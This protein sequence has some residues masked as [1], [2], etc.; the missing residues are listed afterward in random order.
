METVKNCRKCD[1]GSLRYQ[2]DVWGGYQNCINCG[3]ENMVWNVSEAKEEGLIA[4]QNH[5]GQR[6]GY[7][8]HS[9]SINGAM[10]LELRKSLIS[11]SIGDMISNSI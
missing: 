11:P 7:A 1:S 3:W 5:T 8:V 4:W 6:N 9:A 10:P 2:E